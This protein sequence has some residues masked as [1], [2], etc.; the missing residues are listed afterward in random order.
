MRRQSGVGS[1]MAISQTSLAAS[2]CAL[3]SALSPAM[4]LDKKRNGEEETGEELTRTRWADGVLGT[5]STLLS[6]N[7]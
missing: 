1:Q 4:I 6:N 2:G 3:L 5:F 7:R